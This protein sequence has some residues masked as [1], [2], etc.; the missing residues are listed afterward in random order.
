MFHPIRL[1]VLLQTPAPPAGLAGDSATDVGAALFEGSGGVGSE[2]RIRSHRGAA[3]VGGT[4]PLT[5]RSGADVFDFLA[6]PRTDT[7]FAPPQVRG[8]QGADLGGGDPAC[9]LPAPLALTSPPCRLHPSPTALQPASPSPTLLTLQSLHGIATRGGQPAAPGSGSLPATPMTARSDVFDGL[10]TPAAA[11]GTAGAAAA[12]AAFGRPDSVPLLN[13]S[14][15]AAAAPHSAAPSA[16]GTAL[17]HRPSDIFDHLGTPT[18]AGDA[19]AVAAAAL[20][21]AAGMVAVEASMEAEREASEAEAVSLRGTPS[22]AQ[23]A[24]ARR[25]GFRMD[26]NDLAEGSESGEA[27]F[28]HA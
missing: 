16:R 21:A 8:V 25:P 11:G 13:T 23:A 1:F 4:P 27:A 14:A 15:L 7:G 22:A 28:R 6:T 19:A 3:D 18:H 2:G 9:T 20:A 24:S 12:A 10:L 5:A 17:S 26:V